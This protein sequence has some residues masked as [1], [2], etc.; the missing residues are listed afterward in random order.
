MWHP[1][2][3]IPFQFRYAARVI[4]WGTRPIDNEPLLFHEALHGF[5]GFED[6]TIESKPASCVKFGETDV[7]SQF[8]LKFVLDPTNTDPTYACLKDP[9]P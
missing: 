7:I 3:I 9:L 8:L 4:P 2:T 5:T 6:N 1:A